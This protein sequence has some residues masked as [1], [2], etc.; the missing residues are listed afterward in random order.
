MRVR[1]SA[2]LPP[3]PASRDGGRPTS[4]RTAL[5]ASALHYAERGMYVH[6]LLV[7]GKEPRWD[8]WEARATRD[9]ALIERTWG[10]A[11]FN[12]GVACG[13]SGL[14]AVDLDLPHDGEVS[15]EAGVVDGATMLQALAARTP[16]ARITPTLTVVTASGGRHLIY[17][18]P[19]G[20]AL[21]NSARRLGFCIDTR[22]AG[23]YVVGIGSVVDGRRYTLEGS[24]TDPAVLPGWLLTLLTSSAEP[25]KTGRA[26]R[27]A[28]VVTRLRE[29]TRQ[30]TREQ[31]WAYGILRSEHDD[32]AATGEGGRNDRLNLAAY[33]A[34]Q[35]VGAG[36]LDQAVAEEMLTAAA[37]A[38]GLGERSPV[39]VAKTLRSGMTAGIA[40]PRRMGTAAVRRT[41]GAA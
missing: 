28:E 10:R 1:E 4:Q 11:P 13:P 2:P 5:L 6:P 21:R 25:P 27:R 8:G 15:G 22:A 31:R 29:L 23:G 41:G 9:P 34:G 16:G 19:A 32:L 24:L 7:G 14:V 18:A 38:C 33:R 30:G 12:I 35:L 40:R 17:R 37:D 39:E 20:S 26:P 3:H 36:L